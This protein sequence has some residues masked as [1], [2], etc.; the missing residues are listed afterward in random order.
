MEEM[1]YAGMTCDKV[2]E[3][4]IAYQISTVRPEITT[5]CRLHSGAR[6]R[7]YIPTKLN[8]K[9]MVAIVRPGAGNFVYKPS[10]VDNMCKALLPKDHHH[11]LDDLSEDLLRVLTSPD[12]S[13]RIVAI[14]I[15]D[16][17]LCFKIW[18]ANCKGYEDVL[19]LPTELKGA[20]GFDFGIRASR[21]SRDEVWIRCT[22][23]ESPQ[24]RYIVEQHHQGKIVMMKDIHYNVLRGKDMDKCLTPHFS[25]HMETWTV[26]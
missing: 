21:Y 12:K 17:R 23:S 7:M 16:G 8:P 13:R 18:Q 11:D 15:L 22:T 26:R 1:Y 9:G 6:G 4:T 5:D 19:V 24:F 25:G 10:F 3:N 2:T 14:S 20:E